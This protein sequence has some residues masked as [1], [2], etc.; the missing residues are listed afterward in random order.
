MRKSLGTFVAKGF[1]LF[2]IV[3]VLRIL[4]SISPP[5][6]EKSNK[7]SPMTV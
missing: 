3:Y 4:G 1:A 5:E 7:N 6:T 2:N